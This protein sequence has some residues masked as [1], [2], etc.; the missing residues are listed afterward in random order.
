MRRFSFLII[1]LIMLAILFAG[2]L[3]IIFSIG[4]VSPPESHYVIVVFKTMKSDIEFW[5]TARTGILTAAKEFGMNV[6]IVGP[7]D[8]SD[9]QGQIDIM[10]QVITKRPEAIILAASDFNAL[11]PSVEAAHKAGIKIITLD[12]AVNST[13][14]LCFVATD[15]VEAGEKAGNAMA[16]LLTPGAPV[17]IVGHVK[18]AATAID[19]EHGVRRQLEE[20]TENPI[21]GTYFCEN[22]S[23]RAYLITQEIVKTYPDLGGIV[24]LNEVSTVGVARAIRDMNLKGK[25]RVVGFDHSLTEIKMIEDGVIDATVVQKPFNM[26]YLA[27]KKAYDVLNKKRVE[28]FIDT[29]SVLITPRNLYTPENQKL[30]FPFPAK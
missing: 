12:S 11:V 24:A 10:E 4:F 13:L 8:E 19:R 7:W 30:L 6:E 5:V 14:P 16:S 1:P 15:N 17:A 27:V 22:Y 23:D 2:S 28:R 25:V 3:I 9:V 26:G 18:G 20:N 29:G 21:V